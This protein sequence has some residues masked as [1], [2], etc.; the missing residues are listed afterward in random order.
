MLFA[1]KV[2]LVEGIAEK[3]LM[4]LFMKQCGCAYEDEH[5]SIVE[6]GGKHFKYFIELFNGNAVKKKVLCVTDRD[7][8]WIDFDTDGKLKSLS[9]YESDK[10]EH[11]VALNK[12]FPIDNFHICMQTL[13]GRTFEDELFLANLE[14][15]SVTK[16]L[17]KKAM[18]DNLSKYL[19]DHGFDLSAWDKNRKEIDGR[20]ITTI[21][22][23][24]EAYKARVDTDPKNAPNY[25]KIIFAEIFLHYAKDKK[26]DMALGI[27]IEESLLNEDGSSKLVVPQYI[28]DGLKWLLR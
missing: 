15:Q 7:F 21:S 10:P 24:I 4:P 22:K 8:K 18:T 6:I 14:D 20:S 19:D 27:L 13:G 16:I 26:G 11:I 3:L 2:I 1:D 9:E 17:F 28:Q 5:V 23:Y 25:E 12:Q